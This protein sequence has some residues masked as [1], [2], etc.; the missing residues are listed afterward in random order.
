MRRI[1]LC[2]ISH[3]DEDTQF[4]RMTDVSHNEIRLVCFVGLM[5]HVSAHTQK[6]IIR[7]IKHQGKLIM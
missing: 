1:F 7:L 3:C 2:G 4:E 6:A 5:R